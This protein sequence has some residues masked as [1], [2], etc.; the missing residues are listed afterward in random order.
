[1]KAGGK[2]ALLDGRS[3]WRTIVSVRVMN[4]HRCDSCIPMLVAL[5]V[6]Q[7]EDVLRVENNRDIQKSQRPGPSGA[8]VLV[9]SRDQ[10]GAK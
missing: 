7:R 2:R 1:M 8:G 4:A 6:A 9:S 10:P 3:P 5:R